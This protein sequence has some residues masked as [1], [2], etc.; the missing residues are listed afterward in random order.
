VSSSVLQ[1][2]YAIKYPN[3]AS[4]SKTCTMQALVDILA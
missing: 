1:Q 4:L 2:S 3:Y